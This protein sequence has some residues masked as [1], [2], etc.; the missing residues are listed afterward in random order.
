MDWLLLAGVA[1]RKKKQ[2]PP[3]ELGE[4]PTSELEEGLSSNPDQFRYQHPVILPG[5]KGHPNSLFGPINQIV[6]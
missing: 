1:K 5:V 3:P 6:K 4:L 2:L